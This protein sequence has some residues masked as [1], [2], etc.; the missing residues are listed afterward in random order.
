MLY[1]ENY[2]NIMGKFK[3]HEYKKNFLIKD[4]NR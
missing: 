2:K 3:I 4:M 1:G